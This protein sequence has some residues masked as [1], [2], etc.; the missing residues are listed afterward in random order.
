MNIPSGMMIFTKSQVDKKCRLFICV[1][2][3]IKY[4]ISSMLS[5]VPCPSNILLEAFKVPLPKF[6]KNEIGNFQMTAVPHLP[7]QIY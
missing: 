7:I 6:A 2:K 4:Y 3:F 1:W 5:K